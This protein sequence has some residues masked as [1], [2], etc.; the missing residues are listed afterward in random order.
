MMGI[1]SAGVGQHINACPRKALRLQSETNQTGA[2]FG[3]QYTLNGYA[4]QRHHAGV[5]ASHR[6]QQP[7]RL[8]RIFARCQGID[9]RTRSLDDVG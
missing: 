2:H 5:I 4:V 8:D 9:P 3:K 6:G 7:L 1:P